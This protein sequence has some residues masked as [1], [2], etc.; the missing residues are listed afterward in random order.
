MPSSS[1]LSNHASRKLG[2]S[3]AP[4]NGQNVISM[5]DVPPSGI[6]MPHSRNF[7]T[8]RMACSKTALSRA[9]QHGQDFVVTKQS[10]CQELRLWSFH[11]L[12]HPSNRGVVHVG[13]RPQYPRGYGPTH[14]TA[15]HRFWS[16]L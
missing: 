12:R 4:Q 14:R 5:K 1:A 9:L 3:R 11:L 10:F 16:S 7:P 6:G 15:P 2:G 8:K 13:R